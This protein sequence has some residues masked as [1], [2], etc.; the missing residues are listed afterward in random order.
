MKVI[1]EEYVKLMLIM[2]NKRR[3]RDNKPVDSVHDIYGAIQ[4]GLCICSSHI[5]PRY[6]P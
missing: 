1:D 4:V 3:L 5:T 2:V 6:H